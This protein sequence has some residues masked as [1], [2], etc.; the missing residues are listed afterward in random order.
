[1]NHN[2]GTT[3]RVSSQAVGPRLQ[4]LRD[5]TDEAVGLQKGIPSAPKTT[6]PLS[7]PSGLFLPAAGYRNGTSLNNAGTFGLYWS[8]SLNAENP[9]NAWNLIFNSGICDMGSSGRHD[10]LSVR[11]V[12]S[13]S[14]N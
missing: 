11:P 14:K 5:N 8:S 6:R 2:N 1:M 10:G 9:T 7:Q 12:R 13:A 3:T 4:P